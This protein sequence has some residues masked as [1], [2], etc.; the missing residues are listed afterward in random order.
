MRTI[1]LDLGTTNSTISFVDTSGGAEVLKSYE[2]ISGRGP[3]VPTIVAYKEGEDYSVGFPAK[4]ELTDKSE[5]YDSY[6][7]FKIHLAKD[8]IKDANDGTN[9]K[10]DGNA[11]N[12]RLCPRVCKP[13]YR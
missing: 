13:I 8:I 7:N 4:L 10:K 9:R 12:K 1:G 2:P 6:E 11:V 3:Y 5:G